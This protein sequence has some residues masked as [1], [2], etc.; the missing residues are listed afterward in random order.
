MLV[1]TRLSRSA[2][3]APLDCMLRKNVV[4][5]VRSASATIGIAMNAS[6]TADATTVAARPTLTLRR[7]KTVAA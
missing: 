5:S 1:V 6:K 3:R 4:G 2:L 7:Q